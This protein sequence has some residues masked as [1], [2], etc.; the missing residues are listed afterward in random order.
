MT[1]HTNTIDCPACWAEIE[2]LFGDR[3]DIAQAIRDEMNVP[4][5]REEQ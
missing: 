5:P 4:T 1:A 3:P 2:R